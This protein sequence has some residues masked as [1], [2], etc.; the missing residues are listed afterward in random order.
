MSSVE[1]ADNIIEK[2][3]NSNLIIEQL[4]EEKKKEI[5]REFERYIQSG[6][7]QSEIPSSGAFNDALEIIKMITITVNK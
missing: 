6:Y 4:F 7:S 2:L 5:I 3:S 1:G